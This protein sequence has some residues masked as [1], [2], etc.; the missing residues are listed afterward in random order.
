MTQKMR[1][2]GASVLGQLREAIKGCGQ[3]LQQL[4][5]ATGVDAGRLSRFVR[6]Q[7]GMGIE[8]FDTL[9]RVLGL[10]LIQRAAERP[11]EAEP[12]GEKPAPRRKRKKT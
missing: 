10:E 8:A 12:T 3:S 11:K 2:E 6:G 5:K 9:C 4:G 7:R 1:T